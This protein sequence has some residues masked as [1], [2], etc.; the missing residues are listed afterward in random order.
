MVAVQDAGGYAVVAST[1]SVALTITTVGGATLTCTANPISA[2]SGVATFAGCG[3]DKAG[4]YT[5]TASGALT[6]AVSNSLTITVGSATKLAFTTNPSSSTAGTAFT[7]QP[8]V[9]VED[10]GDKSA[11]G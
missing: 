4:T 7:A 8:V 10:A 2:V 6:A 1:V 11:R 5:L 3:I 9:S